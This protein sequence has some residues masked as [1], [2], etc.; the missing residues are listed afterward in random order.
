MRNCKAMDYETKIKWRIR[1]LYLLLIAMLVYMVTVVELGGGDSRIMTDLASQFSRIVFF[2]G[3]IYVITRIVHNKKLLGNRL[4]RKEQM[5]EETDER[6]R[7]L[8]DKSGGIVLD[9]LLACLL[10]ITLTASLFDMTAFYMSLAILAIAVVLKA[11]AY[12]CYS[13]F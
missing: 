5:Q 8:H 13:R 2:G 7:Y 9:I 6:N 10:F 12:L 11:G 4:L 1:I 3:M